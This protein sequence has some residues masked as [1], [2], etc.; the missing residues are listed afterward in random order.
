MT[1]SEE[2]LELADK[3][4]AMHEHFSASH[5]A[6]LKLIMEAAT[7]LT[8][9]WSG[10]NL[11]YHADVY[12]AGLVPRPSGAR[13]SSEWGIEERWGFDETR[14]DWREFDRE[15]VLE[16]IYSR[17]GANP[18]DAR[19]DSALLAEQVMAAKAELRSI[20]VIAAK[21]SKDEI[22]AQLRE[23]A[24]TYNIESA[25]HFARAQIGNATRMSRDSRAVTQGFRI[26]PHQQVIADLNTISQPAIVAKL[27]ADIARQAGKHLN[28]LTRGTK[29]KSVV[30][31]HVFIGHG[32][33]LDWVLLKDF[34]KDR[35][36][37]KYDEFNRVP[38]AG[39]STIDRLSEMLGSA[40][41]AFMVLT[42][43]DEQKDGKLRAR[44][45]VIHEV[46]LFQGRLGFTRAI[47]LLE[48]GCEEF[49][50]IAGLGQIRFPRGKIAAAFE[51][52]RLV[53][54][55]EGISAG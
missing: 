55:R 3:L 26:A 31:N 2:L 41:I 54:E 53:I 45:N 36:G 9:S 7:D 44:M 11:G 50:N 33:S 32:R 12:Y 21:Q 48:E 13:F 38:V 39:I 4:L 47:V 6:T 14:G 27:L 49:S 42:A 35:L 1:A 17:A 24:E 15:T 30:S 40:A 8:R 18:D 46:G 10:S 51:D 5:Q 29:G 43:E 19:P 22:L 25:Q 16:E 28:R 23:K 34:V 20:L 37:L 52:V